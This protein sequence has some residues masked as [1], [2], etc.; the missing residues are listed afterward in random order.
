MT[1]IQT[2]SA[3]SE[4]YFELFSV[5]HRIIKRTNSHYTTTDNYQLTTHTNEEKSHK[6]KK[7]GGKKKEGEHKRNA[8]K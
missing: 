4:N 5:N 8:V 6:N 7:T 1:R 2:Q 3:F